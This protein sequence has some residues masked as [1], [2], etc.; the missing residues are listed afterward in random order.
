MAAKFYAVIE[1]GS[2]NSEK[3]EITIKHSE[4]GMSIVS[5]GP[6]GR[7]VMLEIGYTSLTRPF[8]PGVISWKDAEKRKKSYHVWYDRVLDRCVSLP[9]SLCVGWQVSLGVFGESGFWD[10]PVKCFQVRAQ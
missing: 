2:Q 6:E 4:N 8:S 10:C 9:E 5:L 3:I 1:M 7:A